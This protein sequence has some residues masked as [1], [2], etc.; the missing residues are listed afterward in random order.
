MICAAAGPY[1]LYSGCFAMITKG[2]VRKVYAGHIVI[3]API[4]TSAFAAIL[5]GIKRPL[6]LL[7]MTGAA[8]APFALHITGPE[9]FICRRLPVLAASAR[10]GWLPERVRLWGRTVRSGR[11]AGNRVMPMGLLW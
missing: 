11:N 3:E 8:M 1:P 9:D 5:S 2:F 10:I 4:L 7:G 6:L